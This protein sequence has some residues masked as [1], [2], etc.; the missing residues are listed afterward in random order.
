MNML[1]KV[2]GQA[3]IGQVILLFDAF[4]HFT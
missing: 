1:R 2:G 3:E 4:V